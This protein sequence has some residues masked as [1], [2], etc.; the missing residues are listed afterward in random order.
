[1]HLLAYTTAKATPDLSHI[2]NR[3]HE[4]AALDPEVLFVSQWLTNLARIHEDAGS[5]P[6]LAQWDKDPVLP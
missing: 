1:M 6:G 2:R 4:M 5:I 3:L